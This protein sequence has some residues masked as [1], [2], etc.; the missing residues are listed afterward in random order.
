MKKDTRTFNSIRNILTGFLGQFIFILAGFINR[1]VFIH[2][3]SSEYLGVNGLFTNILS[4]LSLADLGIG[5]AIVYA[6]YKPLAEKNETEIAKLMN[7][8]KKA[9]TSIGVIIFILGIGLLPFLNGLIGEAPNIKESIYLIY[10]I[11]LFNSAISYFA[12]YKSS[13]IIADQKNYISTFITYGVYFFQTIV[14]IIVLVVTKNFLVYLV[15]QSLCVILQNII[16]TIVANKM[17]PYLKGNKNLHITKEAKKSLVA[18]VRA[19][20]LVKLGS[21]LVMNT[22]NIIITYISGL[23]IVGLLSNY[24]MIVN[25]INRVFQQLFNGITASIGNLN[26]QADKEKKEEMFEIVN[27]CNFWLFGFS[28]IGII[29]V[30]NDV[31]HLWIGAQYILPM[32]I[33]IMLAINFYMVGMQNAVWTY[34]NTLGIFTKGRY[35]LLLTAAINL[36]LSLVLGKAIGLFGILLSTAIA[37]LVTNTWYDPYIVYKVGFEKSF[38]KYVI[39]YIKYIITLFIAGIPAYL[40]CSLVKFSPFINV[41]LKMTICTVVPN[42]IIIALFYNTKEMKYILRLIKGILNGIFRKIKK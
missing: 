5:T 17:Y 10:I 4:M 12:S 3:L 14:Q 8:Y 7:F 6:L 1:S 35:L 21:V 29:L 23:S 42:I 34:K 11:Y 40:L 27:F 39:K 38:G 24:T 41:L 32:P 22:D 33:A 30:I 2:C 31:I 25:A 15:V 26:A 36:V 37:R 20:I 13:L 18:D 16:T 28:A 19:L 9:Y